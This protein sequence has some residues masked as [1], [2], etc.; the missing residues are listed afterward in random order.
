M[1]EQKIISKILEGKIFVYPTDTIYGIGCNAENKEAV[2]KIRQ[3]KQMGSDKPL[4]IIAPSIEWI[5]ENLIMDVDLNKY[6]PGPYTLILKKKIP[7]FLN[8]VSNTDSLGVRIP[9]NDFTKIIQKSKVPFI[10][11][12][13]N[14][15]GAPFAIKI[16]EIN[17]D[18]LKKIEVIIDSGELNG[19]PSTLIMNGKEVIR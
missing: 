2:N 8:W 9:A 5:K 6:L 3:I 16:S 11:T 13:V 7:E 18:I 1:E 19:R 14:L 12:S 15:L 4:S 10:T 17:P